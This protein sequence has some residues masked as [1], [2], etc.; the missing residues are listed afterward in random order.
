MTTP[1]LLEN[2][3]IILVNTSHPGN[4]GSVAR[5]MKT[6]GMNQLYLVSPKLFP[7][8]KATELAAGADDIL[9]QAIVVN[10]LKQALNPCRLV[11]GT[12]SRPRSIPLP[13]LTPRECGQKAIDA[14]ACASA[15]PVGLLFGAERSGLSNEQLD[16]CHYQLLIPANPSY[17]SLNLSA[18]VQII[19]YEIYQAYLRTNASKQVPITMTQQQHSK[20]ASAEEIDFF[21]HHLKSVL[22][23]TNFLR[24][25]H[26]KQLMQRLK[27]MFNRIQLEHLEVKILRGILK[28]ILKTVRK[29][30]Q[31]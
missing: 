16:Y 3:R 22:Q 2:I 8:V 29:E 23:A 24:P 26:S 10:D 11:I 12:S 21:Y 27:R 20:R 1:P 13:Y 31:L 17:S 7:H 28:E 18:T 30:S 15:T 6:M 19:C 14:S 4:I 9:D 5:A 25:D